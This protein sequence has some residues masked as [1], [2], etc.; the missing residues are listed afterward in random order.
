[1]EILFSKKQ[2]TLEDICIICIQVVNIDSNSLIKSKSSAK[3]ILHINFGAIIII[4]LLSANMETSYFN[5]KKNRFTMHLQTAIKLDV[6]MAFGIRWC[7]IYSHPSL[8]L[9]LSLF[10]GHSHNP[11]CSLSI[12]YHRLD[13]YK[14]TTFYNVRVP[15]KIGDKNVFSC[16]MN[17]CL[18]GYCHF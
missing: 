17:K 1:M 8:V 18:C 7:I 3:T 16:L 13:K 2:Q 10:L 14:Y 4:A 12:S 15:V 6:A 11:I 9:A 5:K